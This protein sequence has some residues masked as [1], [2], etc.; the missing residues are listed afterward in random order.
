MSTARIIL[1]GHSMDAIYQ[2]TVLK[3]FYPDE[4]VIIAIVL[5][6]VPYM[7]IRGPVARVA[8]ALAG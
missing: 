4:A 6:L 5:A 1:L 3:R 8:R 2:I 7:L